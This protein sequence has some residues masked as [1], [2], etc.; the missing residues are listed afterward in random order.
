MAILKGKNPQ[1]PLPM[2]TDYPESAGARQLA[3]VC[4][5]DRFFHPLSAKPAPAAFMPQSDSGLHR[6]MCT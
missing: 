3:F 5:C 2:S 4:F 1:K 6:L